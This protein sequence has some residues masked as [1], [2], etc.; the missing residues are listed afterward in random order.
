[1]SRG[2]TGA[3]GPATGATGHV[4]ARGDTGFTLIE[5]LVAMA[6]LAV[7]S[8]GFVRATEAHIDLLARL[9][10][11][12]A[13]MRAADDALVAARLGLPATEPGVAGATPAHSWRTTVAS[14]PS[15]DPD[16]SAITVTA[17]DGNAT[18]VAH[19]FVDRGA[20]GAPGT[21]R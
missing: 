13:G 11:R 1:M 6:V 4:P 7:A 10:A 18:V 15:D 17:T 12:V 20:R 2:G 19:G 9:E 8:V 14:R 16:I 21:G 3:M 5:V